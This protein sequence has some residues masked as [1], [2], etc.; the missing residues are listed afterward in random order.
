MIL[1]K[2]SAMLGKQFSLVINLLIGVVSTIKASTSRSSTTP[3]DD[4][5]VISLARYE[6]KKGSMCTLK[7]VRVQR[8]MRTFI[9]LMMRT[10]SSGLLHNPPVCPDVVER[11]ATMNTKAEEEAVM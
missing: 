10:R 6:N 8:S 1:D 7:D 5:T 9:K 3:Y 4:S 11:E 2:W